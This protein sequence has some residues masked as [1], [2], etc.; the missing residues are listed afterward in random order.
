MNNLDYYKKIIALEKNDLNEMKKLCDRYKNDYSLKFEYAKMLINNGLTEE[1]K[2]ILFEQQYTKNKV[3]AMFELGKLEADNNNYETAKYYYKSILK[4]KDDIF[5]KKELGKVEALSRNYEE[6]RK[7]FESILEVKN[8][9][10]T[11]LELAKLEFKVQNYSKARRLFKSLLKS[12]LDPTIKP[13]ALLKLGLL[14]YRVGDKIKAK[15]Y[16]KEITEERFLNITSELLMILEY[17]DKNYLE[18]FDRFNKR[19]KNNSNVE[20]LILLGLSKE[21]NIF[22]D[23]DYS[24]IDYKYT[25]DQLLEYD[26]NDALTHIFSHHCSDN[27]IDFNKNVDIEKLF[28]EVKTELKEEKKTNLIVFNDVYIIPKNNVGSNGEN[29]L[30]VVTLPNTTDV[31]TMYPVY[32]NFI[33]EE[34][35]DKILM[36]K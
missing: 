31:I 21:L 23:T 29:Y 35:Y 17:K 5:T 34:E 7:I 19:I 32:N 36:K 13:Y 28:F 30:Q 16:F 25:M 14:E 24:K 11:V 8:D 18:V 22:F 3:Y 9:P 1:A 6:A 2:E 27:K 33:E 4:I 10:Q 12:V 26:Y 20:N 15:E